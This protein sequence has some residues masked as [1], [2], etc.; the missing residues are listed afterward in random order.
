[1]PD[2]EKDVCR[3][4]QALSLK[5]DGIAKQQESISKTCININKALGNGEV[6]F[7]KLGM[8]T[9]ILELLVYGATGLILMAV[10]VAGL[11][12]IIRGGTIR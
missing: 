2:E 11:A 6:N 10:I 7:A 5:I 12:M 1:M 3:Y 4:H 9:R 8:R